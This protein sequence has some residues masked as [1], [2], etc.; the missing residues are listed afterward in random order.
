V[1]KGE[2]IINYMHVSGAGDNSDFGRWDRHACAGL[3]CVYEL[4]RT[5]M[6]GCRSPVT[7]Q[8][9][10]IHVHRYPFPFEVVFYQLKDVTDLNVMAQR[11]PPEKLK[12]GCTLVDRQL[13]FSTLVGVAPE[14]ELVA[15]NSAT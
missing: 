9:L 8:R 6:P 4:K 13:L 10:H 1:P 5:A 14:S 15:H 3:R 7:S 2:K 12:F 11:R